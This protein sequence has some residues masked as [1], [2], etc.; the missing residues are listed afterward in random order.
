MHEPTH[1]LPRAT[2]HMDL[3]LASNLRTFLSHPL[4]YSYVMSQQAKEDTMGV[5]LQIGQMLKGNLGS[6]TLT[7]Q[8][9]HTVWQAT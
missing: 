6:Y 4:D 7:Q 2:L 1:V 9:H 8:L 3:A 5:T